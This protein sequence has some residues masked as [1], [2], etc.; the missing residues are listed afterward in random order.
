[1]AL[2]KEK[3]S[4]SRTR[5]RRAH[6]ALTKLNLVACPQCKHARPPHVICPN[7]GSYNGR[8]VIKTQ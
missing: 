5:Q 7:C 3:K 6:Q 2:P 8:E 4:H 1:M